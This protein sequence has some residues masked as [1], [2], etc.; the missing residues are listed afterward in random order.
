[1]DGAG[2]IDAW[3]AALSTTNT[4]VLYLPTTGNSSGDLTS[5]EFAAINAHATEINTFVAGAGNPMQ[6][7]ASSLWLKVGQE[8]MAG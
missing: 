5:A 1:M 8:R 3:L 4:G 6:G 2:A 7:R